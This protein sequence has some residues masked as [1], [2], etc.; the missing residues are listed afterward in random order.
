M[1][2]GIRTNA[3]RSWGVKLAF[4]L[5]IVVFVFWGIG[6]VQTP[7]AVVAKVNDQQITMRE[8]QRAYGRQVAEIQNVIP[9]ITQEQLASFN[10]AQNTLQQLIVAKLLEEESE[11]TGID[12]SAASL[13]DSITSF[14]NFQNEDG[15]FD[16]NI[17]AKVLEESGQS[18]AEFESSI[19]QELL[20]YSFRQIMGAG[21]FVSPETAKSQ[22]F[23]GQE[24]RSMDYV[25]VTV[26][27]TEI[28][29][30]DAEIADQYN[31]NKQLY[32]TPPMVQLEYVNFKSDDLANPESIDDVEARAAYDARITQ[33]AVPAQ[34]KARHL[35]IQ[36]A[37]NAPE[38]EVQKALETIQGLEKRVR[39]G[40][41]FE[42]IAKQYG[43]DSTKDF[44]GDLG[45]FAQNQ[46]VPAFGDVAFALPVGELSAPVKT[47]FGYHLI[48]VEDKKE[49]YTKSFEDEKEALR[50]ALA[51]EQVNTTLQDLV[52]N[53]FLDV[54]NNVA[55]AEVATRH[56]LMVEQTTALDN[57]GLISLGI[58]PSHAEQ[59][60]QIEKGKLLDIPVTLDG[61]LAVIK[62]LDTLPASTKLLAEVQEDIRQ[63]ILLE[64]SKDAAYAK[65]EDILKNISTQTPENILTSS[66]FGRD[67]MIEGLG[68]DPVLAKEIFASD[69][70]NWKAKPF[71]LGEQIFIA[72][73]A[74]IK[75]ANAA[76][77][78]AIKQGLLQELENGKSETSFQRYLAM[79][80]SNA[81][82][83]ILTP[84]IFAPQG[85]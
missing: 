30:T 18:I 33:F 72:R 17:Y 51:I 76:D 74:E 37:E 13:R 19:R 64:K 56:G 71:V 52:D 77:F 4:G 11:R 70:K 81:D 49:A 38:A 26:D 63:N 14:P 59:L 27:P 78:D 29:I 32:S 44:G 8:F 69:D 67:G 25:N 46:M 45:W 9:N 36:V 7:T 60:M 20:P 42:E 68:S 50:R 5:I 57:S 1:L 39:S 28:V 83:E 6:A 2:D 79:L 54:A 43:Q 48:L 16:K 84:E 12:I 34:V 41:S 82:I 3:S 65:G 35:L 66:F 24:Q 75:N 58:S 47:N 62:V 53:A 80:Y 23:F 10:V 31:K 73:L 85:Q 40:E 61:G 55:L 21:L 15:K 22:Y